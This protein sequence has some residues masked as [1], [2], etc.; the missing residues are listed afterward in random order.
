M[1]LFIADKSIPSHVIRGL[2]EAG[3]D[4]LTVAEAASAGISD[5]ELAELSAR[6]EAKS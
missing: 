4:V 1:T 5:Y 6:I 3:Y 2:R